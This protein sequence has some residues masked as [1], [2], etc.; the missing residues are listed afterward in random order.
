MGHSDEMIVPVKIRQWL[1]PLA[2][3]AGVA[4]IGWFLHRELRHYS[5]H[6]IASAWRSMLVSGIGFVTHFGQLR[7]AGGL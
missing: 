7:V 3:A 4:L 6:E 1:G 5:Y 2:I